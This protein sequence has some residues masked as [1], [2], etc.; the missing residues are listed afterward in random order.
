[1]IGLT[2]LYEHSKREPLAAVA[3]VLT[4]FLAI[5]QS[6]WFGN[7]F[8]P[9][10]EVAAHYQKSDDGRCSLTALSVDNRTSGAASDI[11]VSIITDWIVRS[12]R[13]DL[14]LFDRET[15]LIAADEKSP[16]KFREVQDVKYAVEG[17]TIVI[18]TL[19]PGEYVDL[20]LG[21]TVDTSAAELR[22]KLS[23]DD[24]YIFTPRVGIATSAGGRLKVIDHG[25]CIRELS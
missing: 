4:V 14:V 5:A 10:V 13:E 11:R 20:F 17:D 21:R 25:E 15:G 18:P 24:R 1:M 7:L 19:L 16:I 8:R 22:N 2:P 9:S 6:E 23:S 3:I 12:G